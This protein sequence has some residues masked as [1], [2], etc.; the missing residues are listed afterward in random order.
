[1]LLISFNRSDFVKTR[2]LYFLL[3]QYDYSNENYTEGIGE[4]TGSLDGSKIIY[5]G[6]FKNKSKIADGIGIP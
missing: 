6:Q 5:F 2:N 3:G 1:M 4:K